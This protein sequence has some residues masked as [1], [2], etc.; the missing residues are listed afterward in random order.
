MR[1]IGSESFLLTRACLQRGLALIFLIAFLNAVNQ[2][3]PLLGERGLLPVP[4]FVKDTPF[5][6]SPSLFFFAPT[7][8]AFTG[9]AW[10]G[11]LLSLVALAGLSERGGLWLSM[12]VWAVLWALYISFVNVGQTFYS[13]GW[14]SIL[15]EAGFL[16]IFM[17]SARTLPQ[18]VMIL[19]VRWLC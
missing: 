17:G 2:F 11:V 3:K 9:C 4:Q 6:S 19:L 13:F 15:L 7:D 18:F 12:L 5:S 10:L 1:W 8:L 14:E 16:A